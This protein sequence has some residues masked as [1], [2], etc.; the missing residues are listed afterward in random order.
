[1]SLGN[2]VLVRYTISLYLPSQLC[3]LGQRW[4]YSGLLQCGYRAVYAYKI[5]IRLGKTLEGSSSP[6]LSSILSPN[7][8]KLGSLA[9]PLPPAAASQ[10]LCRWRTYVHIIQIP[11]PI[12]SVTK[13]DSFLFQSLR[14]DVC[15]L[16]ALQNPVYVSLPYNYSGP[17]GKGFFGL[18]AFSIWKNIPRDNT[19][20]SLSLSLSSFYRLRNVYMRFSFLLHTTKQALHLYKLCLWGDVCSTT[21]LFKLEHT[22]ELCLNGVQE[23]S[24]RYRFPSK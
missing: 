6:A 3:V 15:S 19:N 16:Q 23:G 2:L 12:P 14:N 9:R 24:T 17:I 13:C 20:F 7:Q 1:M 11:N 22:R 18:Q 21:N 5:Q 10:L 4:I 8:Q